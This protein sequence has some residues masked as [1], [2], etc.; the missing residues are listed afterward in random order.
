[1]LLRDEPLVP[2]NTPDLASDLA[3]ALI[4]KA[5]GLGHGLQI[6]KP[7]RPL[8]LTDKAQAAMK[9]GVT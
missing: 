2:A 1:M 6:Y 4:F 3:S 9:L 5:Q 7:F 8:A